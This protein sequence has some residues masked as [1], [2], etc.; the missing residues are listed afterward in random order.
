MLIKGEPLLLRYTSKRAVTSI[1]TFALLLAYQPTHAASKIYADIS[2][3][4]E[5]GIQFISVT[6]PHSLEENTP[7]KLKSYRHHCTTTLIKETVDSTYDIINTDLVPAMQG[8]AP[9][10][11]FFPTTHPPN[12]SIL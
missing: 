7:V 4:R 5:S 3:A 2:S 10:L 6:N 1:I 9:S 12:C 11:S 8:M